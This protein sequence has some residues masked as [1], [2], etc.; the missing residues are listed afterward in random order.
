MSKFTEIM[1]ELHCTNDEVISMI[2]D[3]SSKIFTHTDKLLDNVINE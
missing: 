2:N 1:L 3:V